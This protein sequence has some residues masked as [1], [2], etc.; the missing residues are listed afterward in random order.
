MTPNTQYRYFKSSCHSPEPGS[1]TSAGIDLLD[2]TYQ[3]FTVDVDFNDNQPPQAIGVPPNNEINLDCGERISDT[4][5]RFTGPEG[6][7]R[8]TLTV[9]G[10][11]SDDFTVVTLVNSPRDGAAA[12]ATINWEPPKDPITKQI[13]IIAT[14]DHRSK[15]TTDITI[16]LN[17]GDCVHSSRTNSPS[18]GNVSKS[19]VSFYTTH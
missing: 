16:T 2:Y 9:E 14:D 13:T 18:K 12:V 19:E 4:L 7:Q 6:D 17:S 15:K 10:D 8:V 1:N 5:I 11:E 3:C